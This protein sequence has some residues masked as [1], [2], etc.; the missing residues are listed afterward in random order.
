MYIKNTVNYWEM[1][2]EVEVTTGLMMLTFKCVP[3][4]ERYTVG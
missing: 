1:M 3:S 2:K 4:R